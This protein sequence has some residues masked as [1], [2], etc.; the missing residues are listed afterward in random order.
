MWHSRGMKH[1]AL[2]IQKHNIEHG[3]DDWDFTNFTI[4][5]S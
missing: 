2:A 4:K 5:L 3:H 1:A